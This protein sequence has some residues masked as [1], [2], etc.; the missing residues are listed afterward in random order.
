M[1]GWPAL[2]LLCCPGQCPGKTKQLLTIYLLL[3]FSA[4]KLLCS[5]CAYSPFTSTCF[6]NFKSSV[7]T[8]GELWNNTQSKWQAEHGLMSALSSA[9][10]Y[11]WGLFRWSAQMFTCICVAGKQTC[12]IMGGIIDTGWVFTL[13]LSIYTV[14]ISFC[15]NYFRE[16]L[17]SLK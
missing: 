10:R 4:S 9:Q 3:Y 5:L 1:R 14:Y 6:V 7:H 2:Y 16:L 15:W 8:G 13:N 17:I 12:Q 11:I